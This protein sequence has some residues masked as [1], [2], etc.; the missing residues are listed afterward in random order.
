MTIQNV[1]D[2]LVQGIASIL[3]KDKSFVAVDVPL[4][5]LGIDSLTLT[6]ILVFIE[7]TFKLKLI[8]SGLFMRDF[9]T[10]QSLASLIHKKL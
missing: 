2:T 10:I 4:H 1:E 3:S 9:E 5:E 7:Q 8:E 6:E